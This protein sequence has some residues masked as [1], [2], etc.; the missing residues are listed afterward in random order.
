MRPSDATPYDGP[1]CRWCG[2]WVEHDGSLCAD[3]A[4]EQAERRRAARELA[5]RE[6]AA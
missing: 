3:C 2:T 1:C 6:V 5:G 4:E